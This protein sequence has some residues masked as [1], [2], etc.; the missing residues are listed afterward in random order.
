MIFRFNV[1]F[2]LLFSYAISANLE[3][4]P[5]FV[6]SV[7]IE[8]ISRFLT[9]PDDKEESPEFNLCLT[10]DSAVEKY[11][12]RLYRKRT[13]KKKPV[14]IIRIDNLEDAFQCH[15]LYVNEKSINKLAFLKDYSV[16]LVGNDNGLEHKG[17]HINF[18]DEGERVRFWINPKSYK[19]SGIRVNHLLLS[20]A[21]IVR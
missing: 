8:K 4:D 19:G 12:P 15:I 6:K 13:I 21:K 11:L 20:I 10:G 18:F 9:W 1:I 14:K 17:V 5:S 16:V 3:H 7:Y 2:L